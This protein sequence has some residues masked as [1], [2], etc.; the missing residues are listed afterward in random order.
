M[1]S[2]IVQKDE[3]TS[4]THVERPEVQKMRFFTFEYNIVAAWLFRT[5]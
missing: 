3:F 5:S 1:H 4:D 2:K